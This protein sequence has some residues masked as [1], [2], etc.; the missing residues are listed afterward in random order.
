[1]FDTFTDPALRVMELANE[2]ADWHGHDYLGTE[3]ILMGLLKQEETVAVYLFQCFRIDLNDLYMELK[4][5]AATAPRLDVP[6]R[7]RQMTPRARKVVDYAME[8]AR[9]LRREDVGTEHLLL[10]LLRE[11]EGAAGVLLLERG[12][13]ADG[14]RRKIRELE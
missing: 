9:S 5:L 3:H 2:E 7:R 11:N 1:M 10:G 6:A 13:D 12:L 4:R 8:E 14:V